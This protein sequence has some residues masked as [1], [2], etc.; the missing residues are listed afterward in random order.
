MEIR[1][2]DRVKC[3]DQDEHMLI[4]EIGIVKEINRESL[5]PYVVWFEKYNICAI[6]H[7][8]GIE[9]VLWCTHDYC[10]VDKVKNCSK[11][12]KYTNYDICKECN[13]GWS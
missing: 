5:F 12:Q 11:L 13:W 6:L 10:Y 9:K 8:E 7:D 1:V 2:G 3:L 4:G